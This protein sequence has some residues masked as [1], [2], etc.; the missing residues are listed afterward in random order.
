[1]SESFSTE[2]IQ[3]LSSVKNSFPPLRDL[4][5]IVSNYRRSLTRALSAPGP[6]LIGKSGRPREN[7]K[8][9]VCRSGLSV[10]RPWSTLRILNLL[11]IYNVEPSRHK[12]KDVPFGQKRVQMK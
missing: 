10:A 3:L 7:T 11:Q 8:V 6:P 1:M 9:L 5:E 2:D 12:T 4:S